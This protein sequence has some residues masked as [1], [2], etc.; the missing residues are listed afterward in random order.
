MYSTERRTSCKN[1]KVN[2]T[3]IEWEK[4]WGLSSAFQVSVMKM[5]RFLRL[6]LRQFVSIV[7]NLLQNRASSNGVS[8][9]AGE[10]RKD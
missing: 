10:R 4:G 6:A 7:C 5:K 2:F 1:E 9:V 8:K 3:E